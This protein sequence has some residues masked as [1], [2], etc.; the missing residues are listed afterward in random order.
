MRPWPH[1]G[2]YRTGTLSRA[3]DLTKRA[4]GLVQTLR[5]YDREG[6]LSPSHLFRAFETEQPRAPLRGEAEGNPSGGGATPPSRPLISGALLAGGRSSRFGQ[7]KALYVYRGKPLAAWV[8][9]SFAAADGPFAERLVISSRP[10]DF[11]VPV[12]PD[13][14]PGSSLGG[15]HAALTHAT[16]DWVALAACDMPFLTPAYWRQLLAYRNG[17]DA[18]VVEGPQGRLEP[19]AALYHRRLLPSAE[20]RLQAGDFRIQALL[21]EADARIVSS[22]SLTVGAEVLLNANRLGDLPE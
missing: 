7:D 10:Y 11:G 17:A 2:R 1:P 18:V 16:R 19:L 12:Y 5:F 14:Y 6:R 9:E 4:S 20:R 3:G 21:A 8:L 22:A 15:L 13:I